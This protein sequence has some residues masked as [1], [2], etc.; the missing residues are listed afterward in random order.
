[1]IPLIILGLLKQQPN[2]YGYELLSL[3][4]ERHYQYIVNFTK[5][6]FYYN[7]QQLEEKSLIEKIDIV[8]D[9]K[10]REA[11]HYRITELGQVE[12]EKLMSKYGAKS[13]YINLSFY[14]AMLF[15]DDY[16][17]DKFQQIIHEQIAESKKKITLLTFSIEQDKSL[18]THFRKMLENSRSHH[19]VNLAWFEELLEE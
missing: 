4:E 18:P 14:G 9:K 11:Q 17:K 7:L 19:Q 16:P 5:G 1:M 13:E 8:K 15:A 12:F 10:E 6:S 2:A 3:M